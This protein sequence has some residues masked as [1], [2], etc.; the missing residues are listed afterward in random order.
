MRKFYKICLFVICIGIILI[1]ISHFFPSSKK[2]IQTEKQSTST[3]NSIDTKTDEASGL[4]IENTRP[5]ETKKSNPEDENSPQEKT[6]ESKNNIQ[7]TQK[8][9][10]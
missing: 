10:S 7:I 2:E 6:K 1:L 5:T 8:L 4:S 9:V 3:E